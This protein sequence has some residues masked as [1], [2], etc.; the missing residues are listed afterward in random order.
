MR[1]F[2]FSLAIQ[3]PTWSYFIPLGALVGVFLQQVVEVWKTSRLHR[4]ELQRRMFDAKFKTATEITVILYTVA[5]FFR[6]RLGEAEEWARHETR[7][8]VLAVRQ[9]VLDLNAQEIE[10]AFVDSARAFALLEFLFHPSVWAQPLAPA[11]ELEEEWRAFDAKRVALKAGIDRLMPDERAREIRLLLESGNPA[12]A[13][14]EEVA[15][16]G[17]FYDSGSEDLRRMLPG[18]RQLTDAFDVGTHKG[19]QL[20]REEFKRYDP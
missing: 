12:P 17:A 8:D 16:W 6:A 9:K 11:A 2:A 1:G 7:N 19:I 5:T 4:Q 10:K 18:L 13:V 15:R 20:L 14:H 3:P